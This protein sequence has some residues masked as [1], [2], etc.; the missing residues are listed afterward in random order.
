VW[1]GPAIALFVLTIHF[2]YTYSHL[3][4]DEFM[5]EKNEIVNFDD[6]SHDSVA[7]EE[8]SNRVVNGDGDLGDEKVTN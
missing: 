3:D 7:G 4:N 8:S 6:L 2:Y 1:A 5:L